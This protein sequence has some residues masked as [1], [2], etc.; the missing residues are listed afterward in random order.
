MAAN[1]N[2]SSAV[3]NKRRHGS[4]R[5]FVICSTVYDRVRFII[6]NTDSK[7]QKSSQSL[8]EL[9]IQLSTDEILQYT[10][11]CSAAV[12]LACEKRQSH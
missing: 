9:R 6:Y 2:K 7:T 5:L 1:D 10:Q 12:F 11:P 8:N 4:V 3:A